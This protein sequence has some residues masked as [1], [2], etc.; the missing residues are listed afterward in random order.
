MA[1]TDPTDD[2]MSRRRF[3]TRLG[4]GAG[5]VI[6]VAGTGI[7]WRLV[8]QSVLSPGRGPA[9]EP[10]SGDLDGPAPLSLVAAAIL[11]ANAH[12]TQPWRFAVTADRVDLFADRARSMGAMDP[13]ARELTLSL[14]CALEN[15][16]LAARAHGL[17]PTVALLPSAGDPDH[18]ARVEL[19][20]STTTDVSALFAAIPSRHTDRAAYDTTRTIPSTTL[21]DLVAVAAADDRVGLAWLTDADERI[22]FGRL[23]VD[24]TAAILADPEQARDDYAWYRQDWH[25][26]ERE[27]DGI[28]MD[29][30]G[31]GEPGRTFVRLMPASSQAQMQDGWLT[32]TRDRHV[33][34]AAAYG[35]I[36]VDDRT[37]PASLLEAGRAF[38]RVHLAATALG[39]SIQPLCQV[40]ERVDREAT[41]AAGDAF[42]RG[43]GAL[44][45]AGK[46]GV[47][48][49]RIGHPTAALAL[50]PRRPVEAVVVR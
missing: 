21:A 38:Q 47:L 18:V 49:F 26:I 8:D 7:A 41:T 32:S 35:L 46:A 17:A 33:A 15:L 6:V 34:T 10:W 4:I 11:A 16:V 37:D 31:I 50:S 27:R 14:G 5:A 12:N 40:I 43:L 39:L 36:H 30:G 23:T 1:T 25:A 45:P 19:A 20:P 44:S 42:T 24:A 29:A 3:L 22:A 48:S 13:L 2:G 28:T 9:Y